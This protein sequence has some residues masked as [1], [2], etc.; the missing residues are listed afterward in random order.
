MA[1]ATKKTGGRRGGKQADRRKLPE[2][3]TDKD[4][5]SYG[6]RTKEMA[7]NTVNTHKK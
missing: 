4:H 1:M 5:S 2:N 3:V 6:E 7:A